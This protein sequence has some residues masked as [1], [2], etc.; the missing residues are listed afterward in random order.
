VLPGAA[1]RLLP[2]REVIED[3][4]YVR[5]VHVV[6]GRAHDRLESQTIGAVALA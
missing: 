1:V 3:G 2:A 4:L 5:V 6:T